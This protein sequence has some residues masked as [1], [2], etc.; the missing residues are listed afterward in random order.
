MFAQSQPHPQMIKLASDLKA[1]HDLKIA[2]VSNEGRELTIHRIQKF[3]LG[4]F[5][6]FFTASCFVHCR[7]PDP[8]IHHITLDIAQARPEQVA[9]IEDRPMFVEVANSLGI[10]GIHHASHES[11][12]AAAKKIDRPNCETTE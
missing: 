9:Y 5:V 3:K 10:R 7:K 1:R 12:Q 11:T 2:V 4:T 8:N 6:D